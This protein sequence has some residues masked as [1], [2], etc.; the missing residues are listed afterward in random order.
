MINSSIAMKSIGLVL[1]VTAAVTLPATPGA[2]ALPPGD[3]VLKA[4]GRQV[5]P[6]GHVRIPIVVDGAEYEII[7][8]APGV[9]ELVHVNKDAD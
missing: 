9:P 5:V 8:V 3:L 2:H 7:V 6:P 1:G 4:A